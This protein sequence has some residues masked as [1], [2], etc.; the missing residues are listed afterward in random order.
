M[1]AAAAYETLSDATLRRAYN[2]TL[3]TVPAKKQGGVVGAK[4]TPLETELRVLVQA[5]HPDKAVLKWV[6]A[7]TNLQMLLHLLQACQK[8]KQIPS[9]LPGLLAHLHATE[10]KVTKPS[11][12]VAAESD[13]RELFPSMRDSQKGGDADA[14]NSSGSEQPG[15]G[16]AGG[17]TSKSMSSFVARKTK[18]YNELIRLCDMYGTREDLFVVLDI[19]ESNQIQLDSQTL[20][21][22][23]E[24]FTTG[25]LTQNP[26][27]WS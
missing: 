7:G 17:G 9:D 5:G 10:P 11:N 2:L 13:F 24:A 12:R 15:N 21:F 26:N 1:R 16:C 23:E 27:R 18:A 3:P 22:L 19:M 14:A 20:M 8:A 4:E 6:L 25:T